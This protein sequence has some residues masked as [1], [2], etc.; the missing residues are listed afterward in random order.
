[1]YYWLCRDILPNA[2]IIA[3]A[4]CIIFALKESCDLQ[5]LDWYFSQRISNLQRQL[6]D[7]S[8]SDREIVLRSGFL[9][10]SLW[11]SLMANRGF[12]ISDELNKLGVVLN[13]LCFLERKDQ[14]NAAKVK[15]SQSIASVPILVERAIQRVKTFR[16]KK[17]NTTFFIWPCEPNLDCLLYI[18]QFYVTVD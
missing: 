1:M 9:E 8:I 3:N 16:A 14:L 7:G 11:N 10:P 5:R 4:K 6:F 18:M 2:I 17:W 12:V 13:I 15:E